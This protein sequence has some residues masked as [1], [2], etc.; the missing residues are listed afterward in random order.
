MSE[1]VSFAPRTLQGWFDIAAKIGAAVAALFVLWEYNGLQRDNRVARTMEFIERFEQG[2]TGDAQRRITLALRE[3]EQ[4]VTDL[5]AGDL[6][7]SEAQRAHRDLVEFLA[8]ESNGGQGVAADVDAVVSFLDR[9]A[10]CVQRG[11]CERALALEV[12]G[13]YTGSL[14]SNFAPY[15]EDRRRLAPSYGGYAQTLASQPPL[16]GQPRDSQGQEPTPARS[17]GQ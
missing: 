4:A 17:A 12:F 6:S 15:V 14:L 5:Y 13:E 16:S 9:V 3:S 2:P 11:L 7:S 8:Y 10:I 1:P